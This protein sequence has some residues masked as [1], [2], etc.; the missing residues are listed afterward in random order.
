MATAPTEMRGASWAF[1][2]NYYSGSWSQTTYNGFI[3]SPFA[4]DVV[5]D[6]RPEL[7]L[8]PQV[9]DVKITN[10]NGV[11]G[12]KITLVNQATIA[13]A[14]QYDGHT[15]VADFNGDGYID[16]LITSR[17]NQNN[18][19]TIYNY[20]WDIH[21]N[22]YSPLFS[23][24]TSNAGKSMPLIADVDNDGNL[25]MVIQSYSSSRGT[26][27]LHAY[28]FDRNTFAFNQTPIWAVNTGED[29][30]SN[31]A[32]MFDFNT[33]GINEIITTGAGKLSIFEGNNGSLLTSVDFSEA[34]TMTY[35][36]VADVDNDGHA[37]IVVV[38][39]ISATAG[40]VRGH[41][42]IFK[43]AND[44]WAPTRKV[45]NQYMY[46]VNN[47]N[48]DL[49]IPAHMV[50]NAIKIEGPEVPPVVRQPYN[51]FLMQLPL[52]DQ[53][54]RP[55]IYA[56]DVNAEAF[57]AGDTAYSSDGVYATL[58]Y[59]NDGQQTLY[60]PYYITT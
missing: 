21:N 51:S 57:A 27:S 16:L 2:T 39:S 4:A 22:T 38:D 1:S 33:D 35:P 11:E 3:S 60:Q 15:E 26:N 52:L 46:N 41:L 13:T 8:G 49:S 12:N 54:G 53:Y 47:V 29:S 59:C 6:E 20:V 25:E 14:A 31:S 7:L 5:G 45:W 50:S 56:P 36:V 23:L 10:R 18:S 28:R 17:Y 37:D 42:R 43:S 44:D 40:L 19:S 24:G 32:T 55:F 30:Y 58:H 48:E 34:T 9:F